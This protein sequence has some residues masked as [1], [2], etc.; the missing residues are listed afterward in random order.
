MESMVFN[1]SW[2]CGN[3]SSFYRQSETDQTEYM[4]LTTYK[5]LR[6][7]THL[8][9]VCWGHFQAPEGALVFQVSNASPPL[10]P[11]DG[12]FKDRI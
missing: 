7:Q 10:D 9:Q 4:K 8:F 1:V 6:Y 11:G 12:D 2:V 3:Q 5:T